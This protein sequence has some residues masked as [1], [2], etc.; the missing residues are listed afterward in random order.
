[1]TSDLAPATRVV[2]LGRPATA[3]GAPVNVPIALS[4]TYHA[5]GERGYARSGSD[6]I[7]AFETAV[8]ALEGGDAVAFGSGL[9]AAA[10]VVEGMPSGS[11]AVLPKGPYFGVGELFDEQ[12]RLG[13]M[14]VRRVDISNTDETLKAAEGADLLW[15]ESPVNPT[16]E[17]ADLPA[18][19]AG[20]KRG[21]TLVVVDSTF[22]SP[23]LVRPLEHGADIVM[24]SATKSLAGHSD[25]LMGIL[26][27]RDPA[28]LD[29]LRHRRMTTGAIPG[30][31][32][33]YLALRGLRT[34]DVRLER[35]QQT[36]GVLAER[37]EAHAKVTRVRYPGL[38]SDPGHE[39]AAAQLS[40]FGSMISFE[41][42]G[43]ESDAERVCE[44][45]GLI[46]HATSLGGVES[47]AERRSRYSEEA[48]RGTPPTLI[49]LSVGIEDVEDLWADL[50][51]AL[52]AI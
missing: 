42:V 18:L 9:A 31:L 13:R 3:P 26:V 32:E 41:T 14:Q 8:G 22:A 52:A 29:W 5:N 15:I 24:H 20:A 51:Q 30:S 39:R 27:T 35:Q 2:H 7:A 44:S 47:L 16:M 4:S 6:T 49:R 28:R 21:G 12:E 36:S 40:G 45:L 38:P 17:I 48:D 50:A 10:A 37:L 23:L 19:C 34:L 46:I 33:A 25:L 11:V 43:D 1:M